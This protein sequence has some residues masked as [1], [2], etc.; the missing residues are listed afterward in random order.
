ML[1]K[2]LLTL[3]ALIYGAV[4]PILEV[5]ATHVF[6][7]QWPAHARLH[8]V[9][10]LLTNS[11]FAV[12]ALWLTWRKNEVRLPVVIG[13]LVTLGFLAAFVI[14]DCYGGSMVH[15]DGTEKRLLGMNIGVFGFTLVVAMLAAADRLR[16]RAG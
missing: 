14:R 4:V 12:F 2:I 9:W 6:N 1:P 7:A 11:S 8:E 15:T 5:N 13:L 3:S 10:Q 16:K